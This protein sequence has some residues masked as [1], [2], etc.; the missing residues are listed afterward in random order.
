MGRMGKEIS[1][2]RVL[3]AMAWADGTLDNAEINYLKDFLFKLD[4]TGEEFARIEMYLE[5]PVMPHEA[6][7]LLADFLQQIRGSGEKKRLISALRGMT[8]AGGTITK[9]EEELFQRCADLLEQ[10][11]T[12]DLLFRKFKGLFSRTVFQQPVAKGRA[13]ELHDFL[14]NRILFR[15]RRRM[16]QK[17]LKIE[18]YPDDLARASLFGGLLGL[19]AHAEEGISRAEAEVIRKILQRSTRLGKEAIELILEIIRDQAVKGLDRFR[20]AR[21]FYARSS[22]EER[23]ELLNSLF[24]V[25][26]ADHKLAHEEIE[27]IRGIASI[28]KFSHKEFIEAKLRHKRGLKPP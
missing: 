18:D 3:I 7:E 11:A 20:L 28:L 24:E 21:E 4:L 17:R 27:E 9:E 10:G 13:L 1:F 12:G 25:S 22:P 5:E 23:E 14:N 6:R 16:E 2:L 15:L 8:E 26:G 19:V